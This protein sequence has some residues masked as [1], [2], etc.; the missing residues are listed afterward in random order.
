MGRDA[1]S[2]GYFQPSAPGAGALAFGPTW[3]CRRHARPVPRT[4]QQDTQ[5]PIPTKPY[6][7]ISTQR[8]LHTNEAGVD[9]DLA[10]DAATTHDHRHSP[11]HTIVNSARGRIGGGVVFGRSS[12]TA[13]SA[14]RSRRAYAARMWSTPSRFHRRAS[15]HACIHCVTHGQYGLGWVRVDRFGQAG[16]TGQAQDPDRTTGVDKMLPESVSGNSIHQ[17]DCVC[18]SRRSRR[19]IRRWT[20]D[21]TRLRAHTSARAPGAERTQCE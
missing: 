10:A 20:D 9:A 15:P 1:T 3:G 18:A 2:K 16:A 17:V 4:D 21:R 5:A 6:A 19:S 14:Y 13:R 11:L 7:T 8:I 12:A